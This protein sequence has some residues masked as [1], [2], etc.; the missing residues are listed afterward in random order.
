VIKA[1][2]CLG[3]AFGA[4]LAAWLLFL[5]TDDTETILALLLAAFAAW[6]AAALCF[7]R[8]TG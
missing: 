5:M 7:I 2:V 4:E 8:A 3:A 1:F 6:L